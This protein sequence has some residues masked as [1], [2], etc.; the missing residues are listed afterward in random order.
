MWNLRDFSKVVSARHLHLH[1]YRATAQNGQDIGS[2]EVSTDGQRSKENVEYVH[3]DH[4]LAVERN[5]IL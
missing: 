3:S 5:D 1:V 2:P 4:C